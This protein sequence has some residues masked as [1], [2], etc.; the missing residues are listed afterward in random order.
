MLKELKLKMN[1]LVEN[2]FE[3]TPMQY[4]VNFHGCKNNNVQMKNCDIFLN[5][6][7]NIDSEYKL[8]SP[9]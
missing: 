7:L 9:Q 8:E 3:N 5:F 2:H 6:A 4:T 1:C